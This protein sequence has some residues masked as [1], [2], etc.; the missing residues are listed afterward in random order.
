MGKNKL[1]Y[2]RIGLIGLTNL[3]VR[4]SSFILLPI[5]TKS[6]SVEEYGIWAQILVTIGFLTPLA[7]LGLAAASDVFLAGEKDKKIVSTGF[8]S[9][10]TVVSLSSFLISLIV[11]AFSEFM[12]VTI[13]G[14]PEAKSFVKL[15]SIFVFVGGLTAAIDMYFATFQQIK[16]RSSLTFVETVLQVVL[17]SYVLLSGFGLEGTI[18]SFITLKIFM[19]LLKS[20]LLASQ[21]NISLPSLILMKKYMLFSFP[22]VPAILSTWTYNLSDRYVIGYFLDMGFVGI[23][24]AAYNIGSMVTLCYAP[25][26]IVLMPTISKLYKEDKKEEI[27]N[28]IDHL[29]KL[30]FIIAI[31]ALFG[32]TALSKSLLL[33]LTTSEFMSG[34]IIIP[35]VSLATI[36]FNYGSI[37][38]NILVLHKRTKQFALV[39]IFS[40]LL[41]IVVNLIL[42]PAIGIVG[43]ALSTLATFMLYLFMINMLSSKILVTGVK[44][45]VI[46]KS[47]MSSLIMSYFVWTLNPIGAAQIFLSVIGG[48]LIYFVCFILLGGFTKEEI[49]FLK[50]F[51]KLKL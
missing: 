7:T 24:S 47:I 35:I 51:F 2:Q 5:M 16:K 30:Y 4:L 18:I 38:S 28:H 17:L 14:G 29:S 40:A 26:S 27:K 41:N 25:I 50:E 10:L 37:K 19:F 23:Y 48:A 34:F 45:E 12:S 20:L 9:I 31:P 39:S 3:F 46:C 49:S 21:I 1:I 32:L 11:F 42:V 33:T 36:F 8:F 43:A 44:Y 22:F 13:F 15:I 6:L